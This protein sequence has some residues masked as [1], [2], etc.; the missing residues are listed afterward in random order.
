MEMGAPS[1]AVLAKGG[2]IERRRPLGHDKEYGTSGIVSHPCKERKDGAPTVSEPEGKPQKAGPLSQ[3]PG[4][5]QPEFS[6]RLR[7]RIS[8]AV[9]LCFPGLDP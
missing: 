2:N 1:F 7:G 5:K 3:T 6:P 8:Q 4:D 9:S